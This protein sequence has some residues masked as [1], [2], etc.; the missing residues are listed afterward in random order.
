MEQSDNWIDTF[1]SKKDGPMNWLQYLPR[2][3]H[4]EM[5]PPGAREGPPAPEMQSIQ[6]SEAS[7]IA[8]SQTS[9]PANR[10]ITLDSA[11][12]SSLVTGLA[13][14]VAVISNEEAAPKHKPIDCLDTPICASQLLFDST[15][16]KNI[17]WAD[18]VSEEAAK[19]GEI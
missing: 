7:T 3:S 6:C 18:E 17:F 11:S 15:V 19:N 2:Q 9:P 1:K 16:S 14:Q 10:P 8:T 12:T 4:V 5:W 13:V